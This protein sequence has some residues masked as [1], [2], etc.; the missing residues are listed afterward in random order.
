MRLNTSSEE[1]LLGWDTAG[2]TVEEL[3]AVAKE[4]RRRLARL[5]PLKRKLEAIQSA[6]RFRRRGD[7]DVPTV[8]DLPPLKLE[9]K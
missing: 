6:Q 7:Y 8:T 2:A 9:K 3:G 4:L 1:T 5:A